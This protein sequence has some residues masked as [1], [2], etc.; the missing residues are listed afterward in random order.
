MIMVKEIMKKMKG[1]N[2]DMK[3]KVN[4]SAIINKWNR[5]VM[6]RIMIIMA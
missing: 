2:N 1:N 4:E 5:N 3:K 6:K